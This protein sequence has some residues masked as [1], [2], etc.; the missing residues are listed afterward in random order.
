MTLGTAW[1]DRPRA[2]V[3]RARTAFDARVRRERM[4]M[5]FVAVAPAST[6]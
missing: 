5:F 1:L 4:L 3:Q 2:V 6:V